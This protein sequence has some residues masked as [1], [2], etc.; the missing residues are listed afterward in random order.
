LPTCYRHPDRET[1]VA[2]SNCE[3]PICPD[4][5]TPTPVGMRCPEC[6]GQK[7]TVRSGQGA[8]TA[9]NGL[10][11]TYALIGINVIAYLASLLAGGPGATSLDGG[12]RLIFDGGLHALPIAE[13]GEWYRV[14]TSGFLHAGPLHLAL[15]MYVLWVLG[16]LLEPTIGTARFVGIYFVSLLA[17]SV[18]ALLLDPTALTVGASGAIYGLF[19]AAIVIARGRGADHIVS[20]LGFWLVL[21]LVFTF[22]IPGISIGGHLGGLVGGGLAAFIVTA[23][24]RNRAFTRTIQ[25]G[26]MAALAVAAF[27]I[28]LVVADQAI[29][30]STR[31][32]NSSIERPIT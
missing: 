26:A 5:M 27:A 20:Q 19:L 2:C 30:D 32:R 31:F 24:D 4:C 11:A 3:R 23:A 13:G 22:S 29:D 25:L 14:L 12:G 18:G 6:A 17:G 16:Q 8:F 1:G 21:N 15:N 28:S 9:S 10:P 7:Q